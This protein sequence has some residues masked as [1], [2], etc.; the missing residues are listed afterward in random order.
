MSGTRV[1]A[2]QIPSVLKLELAMVLLLYVW[3][4]S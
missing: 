2:V 1:A 4:R 3:G